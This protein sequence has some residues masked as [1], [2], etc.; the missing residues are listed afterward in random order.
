MNENQQPNVNKTNGSNKRK[1]SIQ[2]YNRRHLYLL[3]SGIRE[4]LNFEVEFYLAF[5]LTL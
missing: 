1:P 5:D 3:Y 2:E 4:R